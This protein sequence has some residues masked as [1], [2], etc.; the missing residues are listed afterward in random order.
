MAF[1]GVQSI[2][3]NRIDWWTFSP[4]MTPLLSYHKQV[5]DALNQPLSPT[6][7]R[8]LVKRV[9]ILGSAPLGYLVLGTFALIGKIFESVFRVDLGHP[10]RKRALERAGENGQEEIVTAILNLNMHS[11]EDLLWVLK[12]AGIHGH[13]KIVEEV[14]QRIDVHAKL[15]LNSRCGMGLAQ[16]VIRD[17]GHPEIALLVQNRLEEWERNN[18]NP[19][20]TI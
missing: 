12:D 14:L 16:W 11:Q 4:Y 3:F 9:V 13:R 1:P 19:P 2:N 10:H 7:C 15:D 6:P 20:R 8:D 5:I 17:N 18:G